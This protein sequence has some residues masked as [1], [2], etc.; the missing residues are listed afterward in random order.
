MNIGNL[1]IEA[2]AQSVRLKQNTPHPTHLDCWLTYAEVQALIAHLSSLKP[3]VDE[4][5]L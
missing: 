2:A 1:R 4:D 3:S 5:L